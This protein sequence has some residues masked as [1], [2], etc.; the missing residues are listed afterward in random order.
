MNLKSEL[1][2]TQAAGGMIGDATRAQWTELLEHRGGS[3][4][5]VAISKLRTK[6]SKRQVSVYEV[7]KEMKH[8]LKTEPGAALERR[9][10]APTAAETVAEPDDQVDEEVAEDAGD[11]DAEPSPQATAAR[12]R[13]AA[14]DWSA[15]L[16][17]FP[18]IT[19]TELAA[20]A[21]RPLSQASNFVG[22]RAELVV[23][24]G[25][26]PK[27]YWLKGD[28]RAPKEGEPLPAPTSPAD[29]AAAADSAPAEPAEAAS[30]AEAAASAPEAPPDPPA[31]RSEPIPPP[32]P[33]TGE[34]LRAAIP[35]SIHSVAQ[36][37]ADLGIALAFTPD[38]FAGPLRP[39]LEV[40]L[41]YFARRRG[42]AHTV[43]ELAD[44]QDLVGARR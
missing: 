19:V 15:L 44:C 20:R 32:G 28:P 26:K 5:R 31:A 35:Q 42:Y 11:A 14:M 24:H 16:Q 41:D 29:G 36:A 17:Q 30:G 21:G 40:V 27:R 22:L 4:V 13:R 43:R 34:E 38:E 12:M 39:I 2:I 18:G 3:M 6:L 1:D 23:G 25:L 10:P 9:A 8:T 37:L 7:A 33:V